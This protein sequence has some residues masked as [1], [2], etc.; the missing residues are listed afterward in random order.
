MFKRPPS[1]NHSFTYFFEMLE[2]GLDFGLVLFVAA[3]SAL[4]PPDIGLVPSVGIVAGQHL[5]RVPLLDCHVP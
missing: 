4:Q 3:E 2:H 1:E 5:C